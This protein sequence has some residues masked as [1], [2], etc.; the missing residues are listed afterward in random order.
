MR[1]SSAIGSY[2]SFSIF[3]YWKALLKSSLW[4]TFFMGTRLCMMTL[5]TGLRFPLSSIE[6]LSIDYISACD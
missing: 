3:D 4:C 5:L 6:A 2:S 1:E